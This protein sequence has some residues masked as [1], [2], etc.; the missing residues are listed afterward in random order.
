[1]DDKALPGPS[2]SPLVAFADLKAVDGD[3]LEG[4]GRKGVVW[5][6]GLGKYT[7]SLQI[8]PQVSNFHQS[9]GSYFSPDFSGAASW[10]PSA[11]GSTEP[12]GEDSWI[13]AQDDEQRR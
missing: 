9:L 6:F 7:G 3:L 11:R 13:H 1:M 12:L 4:A 10:F 2:R 8:P 5:L